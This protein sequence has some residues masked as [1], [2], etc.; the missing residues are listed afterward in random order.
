M[1]TIAICDDQQAFANQLQQEITSICAVQLPQ[2]V[3]Y[4]IVPAF[5]SGQALLDALT[6]QTVDI[7]FLD[8]EMPVMDGFTLANQLREQFPDMLLIFVSA[9]EDRV[10]NSFSYSPFWFLRKSHVEQE[11]PVILQKAISRYLSDAESMLFQTKD[12]ETALRL[13]DILYLEA[14][15]NYYNIHCVSGSTYACRGALSS[16]EKKLE[17]YDF[18]RIHSAY[19]VNMAQIRQILSTN[20]VLMKNAAQ[21]PIARP[22]L[23]AVKDTYADFIRRRVTL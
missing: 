23:A 21:L 12:G 3:D 1:L 7:L 14:E 13:K 8:I 15:H 16:V 10:Y 18:C 4:Q 17:A 22:R 11:L 5:S 9:Y 6:R 2:Q 20:M 19:L